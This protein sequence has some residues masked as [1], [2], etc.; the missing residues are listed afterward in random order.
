MT[1][2]PSIER[3]R[4]GDLCQTLDFTPRPGSGRSSNGESEMP[5]R[6]HPDTIKLFDR[7][8]KGNAL[9]ADCIQK[10]RA[11]Q[12]FVE[13][14]KSS[15]GIREV[16]KNKGVEVELFQK[17]VGLSRGDAWCMAF[18][19]SCLAYAEHKTTIKS[20]LHAAGGCINVWQKSPLEQRVK[21]IPLAG[22]I[23]VWQHLDDPTHGHTGMVLDCDGVSFHAIEG[24]TSDGFE[25]LNGEVGQTGDGVRFTHRRFD[26]FNPQRGDMQ[27][28][29]ALKPF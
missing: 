2:N 8:L 21:L 13:T 14:V 9:A 18:M 27:L 22:A 6:I 20:P 7:L 12:L 3:T 19:Q 5:R 24:N 15:L 11:R 16:A 4:K 25:D 17:T 23:A 10:K 1:A 26:L 28:R 29:G